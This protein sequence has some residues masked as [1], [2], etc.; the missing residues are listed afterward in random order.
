MRTTKPA[1]W[2]LSPVGSVEIP[3]PGDFILCHRKGIV[4]AIIRWG[5]RLRFRSGSRWSHAAF[6]ACNGTIFEIQIDGAQH[7]NID[8]YRDIEYLI[9]HTNMADPDFR[10]AWWYSI[11]ELTSDHKYG[12][13]TLLGTATRMLI[14]GRGIWFGGRTNI[15][16]GFVAQCLVR[17]DAVFSVN[18]ASLTPA[19]LAEHYGVPDRP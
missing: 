9:V 4:S 2:T 16:S 8:E 1:H 5:E 14:P 18:P 13:L 11:G 7:V 10:Q 15:C 6:C 12:W 19:E 3:E 17:G